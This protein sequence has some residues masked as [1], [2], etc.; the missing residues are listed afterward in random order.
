MVWTIQRIHAQSTFL[1]FDSAKMRG[2]RPSPFWYEYSSD[3][4]PPSANAD[5]Y[6]SIRRGLCS[7]MALLMKVGEA[8][9]VGVCGALVAPLAGLLLQ[10]CARMSYP[11]PYL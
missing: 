3:P 9:G 10:C 4:L 5:E 1:S 6:L 11:A 2:F 8:E 7:L